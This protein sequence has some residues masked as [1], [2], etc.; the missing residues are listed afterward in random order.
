MI[1]KLNSPNFRIV[2]KLE[3]YNNHND[4]RRQI[5]FFFFLS[6]LFFFSLFGDGRALFF[7]EFPPVEVEQIFFAFENEIQI[8]YTFDVVHLCSDG[9]PNFAFARPI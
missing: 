1:E 9:F 5:D 7:T 6:Q 8:V 4:G 2:F 3:K